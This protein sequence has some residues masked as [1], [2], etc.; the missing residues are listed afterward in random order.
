[1][2][3]TGAYRNVAEAALRGAGSIALSHFRKPLAVEDK[4]EGA[5]DPVTEADRAIERHLRDRLGAAFPDHG[6]I[7]E[8]FPDER[9]EAAA[10]WLMD[11]IDGTR[12]FMSGMPLWGLLLALVEN[13][14]PRLGWVYQ[15]YMDELFFGDGERSEL[16]GRGGRQGLAA[17]GTKRLGDAVVYS[18]D[19][20]MFATPAERAAYE[21]IAAHCR[22]ARFGGDCYA[23]CMLAAGH[24]DLVV[25]S[26][27]APYDIL[28]LLPIVEGAG[29][30]VTDWAGNAPLAG[31]RVVAAAT[32]A[33][34]AEALHALGAE[35]P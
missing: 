4:G 32:P 10:V 33:L 11:P 15:P 7:G 34:H 31:G 5:F 16:L 21:R 14:W 18:T 20:G 35:A 2:A 19:P 30:V 22:L 25:E 17:A 6:L 9:G 28:P 8:E 24:V 26:S 23:Y 13:G 29:G 27:L 3:S 12:A 1:M